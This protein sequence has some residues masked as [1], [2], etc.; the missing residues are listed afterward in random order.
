M[1][2][3]ANTKIVKAVTNITLTLTQREAELLLTFAGRVSGDPENPLR[4][5]LFEKLWN[6]LRAVGVE[7]RSDFARL[8]S[9]ETR[10][11]K[12]EEYP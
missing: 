12:L 3:V 5:E 10:V 1:K 8:V 2:A 4:K 6:Q 7:D 11:A 9:P